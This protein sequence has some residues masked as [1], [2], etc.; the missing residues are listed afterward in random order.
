MKHIKFTIIASLL[1]CMSLYAQYTQNPDPAF[2]QRLINLGIDSE[3]T[4]DGQVLTSDIENEEE[5]DL[6]NVYFKNLIGLEDFASLKTLTLNAADY[7]TRD[8][9]LSM[10]PTLENFYFHGGDDNVKSMISDVNLSNNPNLKLI[11]SH[12]NWFL[13]RIDLRGSDQYI[14]SLFIEK[15]VSIMPFSNSSYSY[16]P[17]LDTLCIMVSDPDAATN[18]TGN[19]SNWIDDINIFYS[20]DC[21]LGVED[22]ELNSFKIYPNPSNDFFQVDAPLD[23][24]SLSLYDIA[25]K[26]VKT[27]KQ[28]QDVYDISDLSAGIY[29]L[30]IKFETGDI[31]TKK[32]VKE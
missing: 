13:Q 17:K 22:Y 29:M 26:E 19:Y 9:D 28:I 8:L 14:D 32:L 6:H 7:N 30:K 11:S 18:K 12:G 1:S 3:G 5:L 20:T 31:L 4:L 10:V 2:E 16:E 23:I 21:T 25:G 27:Y 24:T 15:L